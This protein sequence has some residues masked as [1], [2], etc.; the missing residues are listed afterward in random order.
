MS[1]DRRIIGLAAIAAAA[2]VVAAIVQWRDVETPQVAHRA[3][4]DIMQGLPPTAFGRPLDQPAPRNGGAEPA[5][6]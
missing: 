1:N 2:A 5:T 4:P 6:R 3:S